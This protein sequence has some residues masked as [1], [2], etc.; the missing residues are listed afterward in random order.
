M[1]SLKAPFEV[2][3]TAEEMGVYKPRLRAFERTLSSRRRGSETSAICQVLG[4]RETW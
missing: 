1:E 4:V 2:M 3:I